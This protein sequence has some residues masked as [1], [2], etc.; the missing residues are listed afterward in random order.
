MVRYMGAPLGF[1]GSNARVAGHWLRDKNEPRAEVPA[2]SA[3][4]IPVG[5]PV[6][7][8][9]EPPRQAGRADVPAHAHRARSA[10]R[11][12]GLAAR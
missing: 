11:A 2:P 10:A 8:G 5:A 9:A 6:H 1:G 12:R 3:R 4:G 7:P